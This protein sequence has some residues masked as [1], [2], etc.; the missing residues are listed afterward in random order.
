MNVI[1]ACIDAPVPSNA[2]AVSGTLPPGVSTS[3]SGW[4]SIRAGTGAGVGVGG[5]IGGGGSGGGGGTGDGAGPGAG[6]GA[7]TGA[8]TGGGVSSLPLPQAAMVTLSSTMAVD[9]K[10]GLAFML[11]SVEPRLVKSQT[12]DKV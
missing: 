12:E 6:P 8:G 4:S 11:F 2:R 7:G 5:G 9:R 1:V 10:R 3:R